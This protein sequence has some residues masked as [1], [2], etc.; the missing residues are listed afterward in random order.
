[1]TRS[2]VGLLSA[3]ASALLLTACLQGTPTCSDTAAT[4]FRRLEHYRGMELAPEPHIYGACNA[5]FATADDP[6]TVLEAYRIELEASGYTV[7]D[8]SSTPISDETEAVIGRAVY[9]D[10]RSESF[11]VS[12]A[13][14][15][16]D[17]QEPTYNVFVDDLDE[18]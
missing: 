5:I 9:L 17:G 8:V 1:M 14:E 18:P 4:E 12:V 13:A 7:Q 10:A 6:D 3:I 15:V 11:F 16:L 2:H